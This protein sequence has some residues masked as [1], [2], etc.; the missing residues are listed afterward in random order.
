[1]L[2]NHDFDMR[3]EAPFAERMLDAVPEL[4][5]EPDVGWMAVAGADPAK[6][7]Q[8]YRDRTP[9]VHLKDVLLTDGGF[10]FRPTGYGSVNT[11]RLMPFILACRPEWLM[12]DHDDAYGRDSYGDLALSLQYVRTLCAI[13]P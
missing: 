5:F 10:V 7:L 9:V 13:E 1:M 11:P 6:F 12:V 3:G 8:K 2:H 4:R